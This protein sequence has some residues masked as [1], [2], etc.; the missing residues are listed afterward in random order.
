MKINWKKVLLIGGPLAVLGGLLLWANKSTAAAA[1]GGFFGGGGSSGS[2][3]GSGG[4]GS[5]GSPVSAPA[6]AFPLQVGSSNATVK[7]LQGYL[8]VTQDG[9]FGPATASALYLNYCMNTVPDQA[10]LNYIASF[11]GLPANCSYA[12]PAT[13]TDGFSPVYNPGTGLTTFPEA[14]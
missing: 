12:A 7:V 10:T 11:K 9:V 4:G 13:P 6:N 5:S 3:S 8:G 14:T 2:S 1:G